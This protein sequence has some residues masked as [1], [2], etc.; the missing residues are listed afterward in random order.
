MDTNINLN[1]RSFLLSSSVALTGLL[2][3]F[4]LPS[5]IQ[6]VLAAEAGAAPALPANAFIRIAPDNTITIVINRLEM[7]QGVNT[8]MAQLIAEELECDWKKIVSVASDSGAVYNDPNFHMIMTGGSTSVKNSWDQYRTLGAGM[9]EMLKTA[10]SQ[11]WKVPVKEVSAKDGYIHHSSKGKLSYGELAEEA[12][13]LEFPKT[14]S[15][16]SSKDFKIIGKSQKRIDARA[17]SEGTAIFG[18]DIRLPKMVY[19]AVARP[20]IRTSKLTSWNEKKAKA[21]PGVLDVFK[22]DDNKIAVIAENTFSAKEG[23]DALEAKWDAGEFSKTTS[24]SLMNDFKKLASKKGAIAKEV[25][26]VATGFEKS[27]TTI[28]AEY[29]FPFLAHAAMEPLNCTIDFDGKKADLYGGFQMPTMDHAAAAKIFG[30]PHDKINFHIS[31]AGGSFGRRGSKDSD[32]I[33]DTCEIAKILKKPVKLVWTREDDMRGG[34]YRPMVFHKVSAGLDEKNQLHAW[35]HHIVGQSITKGT[36]L[37]GFMIKNGV[38]AVLVEGVS[39]SHYPMKN[40]LIEQTIAETPLTSLWWRSVG[41]THTSFVM[42]TMID[43]LAHAKNLDPLEYRLGL[44]K[45]SP[46][47]VAVLNLLKKK[48]NWGKAKAPKGRAWGLAI[49]DSFNSVV[50]HVV[51]VS[52][53]DNIPTVHKVWS[54]VHCGQVV[55]PDG[56]ATQVEGAIV[57]GLSAAFNQQIELKDGNIQQGN[58]DDYEVLRMNQMPVVSVSFVESNEAPTGLGEPGVPPVAPAVANALFKLTNKRLRKLP[59]SK[60]LKA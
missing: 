54:A 56:A 48:T 31:Y 9:R 10:A 16:K 4:H 36:A 12:N 47:H 37:E 8:S 38:E 20:G 11:R 42:E 55:N 50:G 39:D 23:R 32:W 6:R 14:P 7:G 45:D 15:L 26:S 22:F 30:I 25:G 18:M 44:L 35:K 52:I 21:V 13:K 59:F 27:K 40:A 28:E 17:K 58:F 5:P 1:R 24:E 53:K 49:H 29:E 41:H 34:H 60:E 51:E 43:E 3:A 57:F 33:K 19:S 2:V 46:R